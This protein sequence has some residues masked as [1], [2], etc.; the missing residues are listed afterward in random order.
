MR[1]GFDG[2]AAEPHESKP[3]LTFNAIGVLITDGSKN[4]YNLQKGGNVT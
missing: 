3:H 2:K 4:I 1:R